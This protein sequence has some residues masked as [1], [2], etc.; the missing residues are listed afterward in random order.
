MSP[1]DRALGHELGVGY[2]NID[3]VIGRDQRGSDIYGLDNASCIFVEFD[4]VTNLEGSIE[5]QDQSRNE[6]AED[7]LKA[8]SK[9]NP[10]G[11]REY[12]KLAERDTSNLQRHHQPKGQNGV[13]QK[14]EIVYSDALLASGCFAP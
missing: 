7:G 8:K 13:V 5:K 14:T 3:V 6:V 4:E 9:A 1:V 11:A 10:Y 2:E 12:C